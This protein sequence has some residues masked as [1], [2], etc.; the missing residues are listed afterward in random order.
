MCN[1]R[2][3]LVS[4]VCCCEGAKHCATVV[5]AGHVNKLVC[6]VHN[7]QVVGFILVDVEKHHGV[8]STLAHGRPKVSF[9][10]SHGGK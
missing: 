8:E 6:Q 5:T 3:L 9:N 2:F 1:I 4:E 10:A 7:R